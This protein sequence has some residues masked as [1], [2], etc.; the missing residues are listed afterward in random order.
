MNRRFKIQGYLFKLEFILFIC[1]PQSQTFAYSI[2]D[3]KRLPSEN[4]VELVGNL[5]PDLKGSITDYFSY[6][7]YLSDL[8]STTDE[9]LA[10]HFFCKEFLILYNQEIKVRL[11]HS[12]KLFNIDITP[13]LNKILSLK[14][15]HLF[16]TEMLIYSV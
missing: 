8:F 2:F 11:F 9:L 16:K 10:N 12:R 5:K 4:N 14:F 13:I 3:L 15:Y 7:K 6:K 1:I